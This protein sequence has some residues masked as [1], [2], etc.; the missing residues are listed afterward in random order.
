MKYALITRK[1]R[2]EEINEIRQLS[3]TLI[4]ERKRILMSV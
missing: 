4:K 3:L 2:I 1:K